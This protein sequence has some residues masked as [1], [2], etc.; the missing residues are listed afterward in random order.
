MS[1]SKVETIK[2]CIIIREAPQVMLE[3][4]GTPLFIIHFFVEFL[5]T[6]P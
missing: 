3:E 1:G 6:S 5:I 2:Y 4:I